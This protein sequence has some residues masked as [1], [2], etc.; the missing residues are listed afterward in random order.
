MGPDLDFGRQIFTFGLVSK[1][2]KES[3]QLDWL[4]LLNFKNA[5]E[6]EFLF[7]SGVNCLVGPNG[8]GK[9][10]LLDAIYYLCFTRSFLNTA[11]SQN[12]RQNEPTIMSN[13]TNTPI[14]A[15]PKRLPQDL[16]VVTW[17]IDASPL[18]PKNIIYQ[19]SNSSHDNL[20]WTNDQDAQQ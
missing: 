2:W 10:N 11:D 17:T 13:P 12:I 15:P 6:K 20:I 5:E 18:I 7:E 3:M 19:N 16:V 9:T 1:R 8:K 14:S 4:H